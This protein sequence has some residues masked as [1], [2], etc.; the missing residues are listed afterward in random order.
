[1]AKAIESPSTPIY[2]S[3]PLDVNITNTVTTDTV[4]HMKFVEGIAVIT[5]NTDEILID[6]AKPLTG[7]WRIRRVEFTSRSYASFEFY[8]NTTIIK[9]G[10]TSPMEANGSMPVEPWVEVLPADN[11]KVVYKQTDGIGVTV[12]ARIYYTE[13]L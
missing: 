3:S 11:L 13:H 8:H 9:N 12:S 1:M 4:G 2:A 6:G 5:P 7:S 10:L